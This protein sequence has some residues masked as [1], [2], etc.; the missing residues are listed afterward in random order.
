MGVQRPLG[1][2][3]KGWKVADLQVFNDELAD[4]RRRLQSGAPLP[5]AAIV[6][7]ND[8]APG[9]F[10]RLQAAVLLKKV[11]PL[12]YNAYEGDWRNHIKPFFGRYALSAIDVQLANRY[13]AKR[14]RAGAAESTAKN[15]MTVLSAMLT[16]AVAE[17]LISAN[18]L[19]TPRRGRHA[20]RTVGVD[21]TVARKPPKHLQVDEAR[22]LLMV[23]PAEHL[24]MPAFVLTHGLRR[25]EAIGVHWEWLDFGAQTL[26]QR[27]QLQWKR[28]RPRTGWEIRNCKYDS[29]RLLPFYDGAGLLARR[30]QAAGIAFTDPE[31]SDAW[32]ESRPAKVYLAAAYEAAGIR[33]QGLMWKVLRDTYASVLAQGGIPQ[34]EIELLLGHKIPGTTGRYLHLMHTTFPKVRAIMDEAFGDILRARAGHIQ[35]TP[36][37]EEEYNA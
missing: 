12:T 34:A 11:S 36:E 3:P 2:L 5:P 6:T 1:S 28:G 25:N 20:G 33:R 22:A 7:L 17:G 29:N 27:G 32:C 4:L 19:R 37:R 8:Y 31:T 13:L 24:D 23:L 21:L 18:V 14:L 26:D 16:D 15:S 35:A 10:E 9:W 30:R